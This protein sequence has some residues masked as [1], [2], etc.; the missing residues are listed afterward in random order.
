MNVIA[1]GSRPHRLSPLHATHQRL[2]AQ[3][4]SSSDWQVPQVYDSPEGEA[5]AVRERVGIADLSA[6][7]KL[8]VHGKAAGETLAEVFGLAPSAPGTVS[9][10]MAP[11]DTGQGVPGTY[12]ARL[13]PDEFLV[14]TPPG[15]DR[16][17][18]QGIEQGRVAG[19]HFVSVVNQSSGLA[20][21]LVAGPRSHDLLSKLCALPLSPD[22]LPDRRVAQSRL[23][24][25]HVI[26]VR[27]DSGGLPAFELYFERPYAEYVW[28]SLM[29][30]G[31]EFGVIPFGWEARALLALYESIS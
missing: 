5:A 1:P 6:C 2:G 3:F 12:V 19:G 7:G 27:V 25:V 13:T 11:T 21:L 10:A 24:K 18:A 9:P 20:G 16:E 22:E 23:A 29:D 28:A 17:A 14:I 15:E 26:L 30:A 31:G 4:V 8:I